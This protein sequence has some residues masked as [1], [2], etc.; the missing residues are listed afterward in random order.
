MS[1]PHL[2]RVSALTPPAFDREEVNN[3]ITQHWKCGHTSC[4]VTFGKSDGAQIEYIMYFSSQ[5]LS[6][7]QRY[8]QN[9]TK[10]ADDDMRLPEAQH[11]GNLLEN[12][13]LPAT[14]E[15]EEVAITLAGNHHVWRVP[16]IDE[17]R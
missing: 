5:C 10:N 3:F 7:I 9:P 14:E 1:T 13:F 4:T 2:P 17:E 16:V 6:T 11:L 8:Q 15:G 12:T